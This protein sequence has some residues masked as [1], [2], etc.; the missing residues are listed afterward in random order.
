MVLAGFGS[1]GP[2]PVMPDDTRH[3]EGAGL[4]PGPKSP[5]RAA[6]SRVPVDVYRAPSA[7]HDRH[8]S[9][10]EGGPRGPRPDPGGGPF[11]RLVFQL[12]CGIVRVEHH[13]TVYR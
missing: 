8:R 10:P 7:R 5:V 11:A 1:T 13:H 4:D 6:D 9:T 12:S 2:P 3:D